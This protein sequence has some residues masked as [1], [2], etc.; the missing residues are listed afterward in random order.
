[1]KIHERK[2]AKKKKDY[3]FG[4]AG[5]HPEE[6]YT[7]ELLD[8]PSYK[9][10]SVYVPD[11]IKQT[12]N[13]WAKDMGLKKE[14]TTPMVTLNVYD[15][16]HPGFFK[17]VQLSEEYIV[18][19]LGFDRHTLSEAAG[20]LHLQ[21]MIYEEHLVLEGFIDSVRN[22]W[23]KVKQKGDEV[24]KLVG[25]INKL[26]EDPAQLEAARE[27]AVGLASRKIKQIEKN[28][29]VFPAVVKKIEEMDTKARGA[30]GWRGFLTAVTLLVF[31]EMAVE[32][33]DKLTPEG[34]NQSIMGIADDVHKDIMSDSVANTVTS[35][36]SY[37]GKISMQGMKVLNDLY[38]VLSRAEIASSR[39]NVPIMDN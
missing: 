39:T 27:Q 29:E 24:S 38:R 7:G 5:S 35:W 25:L 34:M 31:A 11:D 32:N 26:F 28:P 4:R 15:P 1:M 33:I 14:N 20:D 23:N 22:L 18:A 9:E 36:I 2:H 16:L 17:R 12:I 13:K 3:G 10:K 30:G 8:D 37:L 6:N 19:T 21:E